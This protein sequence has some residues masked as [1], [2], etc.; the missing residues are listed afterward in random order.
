[1]FRNRCLLFVLIGAA[2]ALNL[3]VLVLNISLPTRAAVSGMNFKT[4]ASDD[5]FKKAV[6]TVVE[7]CTVNASLGKVFC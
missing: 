3:F 1:V 6:Q 4:L 2:T 5:D 7:A